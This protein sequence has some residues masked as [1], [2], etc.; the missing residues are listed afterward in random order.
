MPPKRKQICDSD[1]EDEEFEENIKRP[2]KD[3][4]EQLVSTDAKDMSRD[5]D[6]K[7]PASSSSEDDFDPSSDESTSDFESDDDSP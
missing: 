3:G 5:N 7:G 4:S 2:T 6:L 1:D